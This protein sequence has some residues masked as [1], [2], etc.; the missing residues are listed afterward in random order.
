MNCVC[1]EPT[2]GM[3]PYSRRFTWNV[4]RQHREGR[5]VILITHFMDEAD[6]L[7]DRIAIMG[8]GRV[9]CCG[10]P[11]FLKQRYGVGYNMTV[12]KEN[13][14]TFNSKHFVQLVHGMIPEAKMLTDVGTE[15][16]FQLPFHSSKQF[17]SLFAF[18]DQHKQEVGIQS[19]GMSVTTLEEVFIKITRG[20]HTNASATTG[21][22]QFLA[23][24]KKQRS[25][26]S[27]KIESSTKSTPYNG[28]YELVAAAENAATMDKDDVIAPAEEVHSFEKIP[29]NAWL[30]RFF[31]HVYAMLVKR[32]KYFTRDT[33][34]WIYQFVV[35]VAFVVAGLMI[36]VYVPFIS[37][38]SSLPLD[39]K[40]YNKG[41]Y[42]N[43]L[44][45]PYAAAD[46]FCD[47]W[48]HCSS[49]PDGTQSRIMDNVELNP[50]YQS[51]PVIPFP[52]V[53]SIY[54]MSYSLLYP[55]YEYKASVFGAMSILN[56]GTQMFGQNQS[57]II[58]YYVHANYT[59][60]YGGPVFNTL[61]AEAYVRTYAPNTV[62]MKAN[63]HP[64]PYTAVE[65]NLVSGYV[66]DTAMSFMIL[67]LAMVPAAFSMN[68]V[69]EREVK[70]KSQQ[71]LSGVSIS[72]YWI[73]T[74]LWYTLLLALRLSSN[75]SCL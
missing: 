60:V 10:S 64:L 23:Q 18:M 15:L 65:G 16:T 35:P 49:I 51:C 40:L 73:S 30:L 14:N 25:N 3:D 55:S 45:F 28:N 4:I 19:Y 67:G 63:Y 22:D 43:H 17:Q 32:Y 68:V 12:E 50:P 31:R 72:A 59:A 58:Q 57:N 37:T 6:L 26:P 9:Q 52:D 29:E 24:Q 61:F 5:V 2:S 8:D 54:N 71:M 13:V 41:I 42:E 7:G 48:N 70:A 44:P 62:S 75:V 47:P 38:Q 56:N 34:T 74:F 46:T 20:T 36:V 66:L 33:K 27:L 39:E 1:A 53:A 21:R 11:L 69:R